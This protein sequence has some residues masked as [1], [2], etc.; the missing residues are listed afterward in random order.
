[1]KTLQK[2]VKINKNNVVK[3]RK[4]FGSH[5]LSKHRNMARKRKKA[6]VVEHVND[7]TLNKLIKKLRV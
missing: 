5:L 3:R 2:R 4:A 7:S 6:I 1:M